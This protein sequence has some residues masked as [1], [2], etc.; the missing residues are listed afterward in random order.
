[1]GITGRDELVAS[2]AGTSSAARKPS[3]PAAFVAGRTCT[4][5]STALP[6]TAAGS[7]MDGFGLACVRRKL[8]GQVLGIGSGLVQAGWGA[9]GKS[10]QR[11]ELS[12]KST[13]RGYQTGTQ[14][15]SGPVTRG[16]DRHSRSG[17]FAGRSC[18]RGICDC[19]RLPLRDPHG[20]E[21]VDRLALREAGL[22]CRCRS[23][24]RV[25]HTPTTQAV[26]GGSRSEPVTAGSRGQESLL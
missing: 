18:T 22:E 23:R 14:T 24:H 8:G 3:Q 1:M 26:P 11:R 6:M 25:D 7:R 15:R 16:H 10:R 21:E 2:D 4:R 9:Q 19:P 13:A 17:R 5:G 12:Y 20:K